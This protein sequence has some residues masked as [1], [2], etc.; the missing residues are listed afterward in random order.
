MRLIQSRPPALL[1]LLLAGWAIAATCMPRGASARGSQL[2][3]AARSQHVCEGSRALKVV[4]STSFPSKIYKQL[5]KR[6]GFPRH[7]MGKVYNVASK[8]CRDLDGDGRAEMTV[9]LRCCTV[10]S[11]SPWAIFSRGQHGWRLRYYRINVSVWRLRTAVFSFE[12]DGRRHAAIEEK[13]PE[14][15]PNSAHCCPSSY[16]YAYTVWNGRRYVHGGPHL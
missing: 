9:L 16:T 3:R 5:G 15:G 13:L 14:Y 7:V 4:E 11:P 6:F 12:F 8:S 1:L 10:S 2:A